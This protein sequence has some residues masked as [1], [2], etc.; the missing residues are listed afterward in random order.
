[1]RGEILAIVSAAAKEAIAR[2]D[3]SF[4]ADEVAGLLEDFRIDLNVSS[5]AYRKRSASLLVRTRSK[6]DDAGL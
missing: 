3:L 4:V 6:F 5:L 2:N 1:M